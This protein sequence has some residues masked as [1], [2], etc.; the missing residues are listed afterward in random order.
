MRAHCLAYLLLGTTFIFSL[1][2]PAYTQTRPEKLKEEDLYKDWDKD[3]VVNKYDICPRKK[4]PASNDG[5]PEVVEQ[6]DGRY[7]TGDVGSFLPYADRD[8]DGVPNIKDKCP[9]VPGRRANEGC[10]ADPNQLSRN[11]SDTLKIEEVGEIRDEHIIAKLFFESKLE[12]LDTKAQQIVGEILPELIKHPQAPIYLMSHSDPKGRASDNLKLSKIRADA[13]KAY[14]VENG[15][16]MKRIFIIPYGES[17]APQ[18]GWQGTN[19]DPYRRVD[20]ALIK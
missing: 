2:P 11:Q 12:E 15:I 4:G 5:C 1:V 9:D 16:S 19:L 6:K 7:N 17:Q 8:K 13:V 18:E 14:L 20:L 3:G 10:P